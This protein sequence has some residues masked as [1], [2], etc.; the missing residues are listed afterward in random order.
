S[1]RRHTRSKRDWSSDVCSSDLGRGLALELVDL[2]LRGVHRQA[3]AGDVSN[4]DV[5]RILLGESLPADLVAGLLEIL[6]DIGR[7]GELRD[8]SEERRGG[9]EWEMRVSM[10]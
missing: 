6:E 5:V 3:T 1:R 8:R 2:L 4:D 9:E 7:A 10:T